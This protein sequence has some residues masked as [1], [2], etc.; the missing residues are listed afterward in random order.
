MATLAPAQDRTRL[1]DTPPQKP[2]AKRVKSHQESADTHSVAATLISLLYPAKC[3]SCGA[4]LPKGSRA[5]WSREDKRATCATCAGEPEEID[6]GVAGGSAAREWQRRHDRRERQVRNRWGKLAGVALA[7]SEDPHST[8]AWAYGANGEKA[9]GRHLD[10]LRA[11]GLA[12]LH[13]RRIP[14]SRANID[15]VVI[16]RS[17]VWVIDAKNYKGRV[18]RRDLGGLFSSDERLYVGGRDKTSLIR[19]M[20]KQV[21]AVSRTRPRF[22][23]ITA[24]SSGVLHSSRVVV[25]C[26]AVPLRRRPRALGRRAHEATSGRRGVDCRGHRQG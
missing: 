5:H 2:A 1:P 10:P 18:E 14:G 4:D 26:Q 20:A 21:A 13:D 9:L 12:V 19:G 24:L 15:H 25:L 16:A 22:R 8:N 23:R 7:R 3:A 17:G 6:H 11:E